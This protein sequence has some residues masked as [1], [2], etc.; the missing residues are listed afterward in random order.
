M[1]FN[2]LGRKEENLMKTML[3]FSGVVVCIISLL[4]VIPI[5]AAQ[6][7]EA[8]KNQE[9]SQEDKIAAEKRMPP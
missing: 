7:T 8:A 9:P 3:S 5:A 6:E 1:L 4:L 2:Q